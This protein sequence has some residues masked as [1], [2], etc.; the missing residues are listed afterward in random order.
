MSCCPICLE[1]GAEIFTPCKHTF[2]SRC[3]TLW[4]IH[5]GTNC[6]MCRIVLEKTVEYVLSQ[7]PIKMSDVTRALRLNH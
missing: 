3:L 7:R 4:R 6:P 2:H 5:G 1:L